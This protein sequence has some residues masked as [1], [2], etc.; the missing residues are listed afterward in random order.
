MTQDH[1]P[2]SLSANAPVGKIHSSTER[3]GTKDEGYINGKRMIAEFQGGYFLIERYE[4]GRKYISFNVDNGRVSTSIN[5]RVPANGHGGEVSVTQS[6][7]NAVRTQK[8]HGWEGVLDN[9]LG[10]KIG[11]LVDTLAKQN[12]P[13]AATMR[14]IAQLGVQAAQDVEVG[15]PHNRGSSTQSRGEN[16]VTV[17]LS[18]EMNAQGKL[19]RSIG[20]VNESNRTRTSISTTPDGKIES[21]VTRANGSGPAGAMEM[22][23]MDISGRSKTISHT[24]ET[25]PKLAAQLRE[26]IQAFNANG[27][28]DPREHKLSEDFAGA[29]VR[30]GKAKG[31]QVTA[32]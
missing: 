22:M 19:E 14:S 28:I 1:T 24:I 20:I 18:E 15:R 5:V 23:F 27:D 31:S 25:N 32:K 7:D 3:Y 30:S 10:E 6:D 26:N 8:F 12:P 17:V 2:Y 21:K 9:S 4:N 16:G 13:S 29:A 11:A